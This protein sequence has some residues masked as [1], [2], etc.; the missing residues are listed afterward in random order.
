MDNLRKESLTP[1]SLTNNLGTL[2]LPAGLEVNFLEHLQSFASAIFFPL[3]PGEI[4]SKFFPYVWETWMIL[5]HKRLQVD[6]FRIGRLLKSLAFFCVFT[7]FNFEPWPVSENSEWQE[8]WQ[9]IIYVIQAGT[10]TNLT[11]YVY[12]KTLKYTFLANFNY[13]KQNNYIININSDRNPRLSL[14]FQV[15]RYM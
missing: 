5:S 12:V 6:I 14:R 13:Y 2:G 11:H 7:S 1:H 10:Q 4:T 3:A 9:G 8:D 15:A